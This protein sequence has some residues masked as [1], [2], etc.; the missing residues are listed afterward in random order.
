MNSGMRIAVLSTLALRGILEQFKPRLEQALGARLEFRFGA[1]QAILK[2]LEAADE[3]AWPDLL[4]LTGE[5]M[6]QLEAGGKVTHVRVL[7]SSGV[8]VAVRA[9]A[10]KPDIGTLEAFKRAI[11]DANSVAHSKVGASGLYFSG[12]IE[13]IPLKI[14]KRVVVESG[15][16]GHAVAAGEAEIGIQQL[17]ELA[18]VAGIDI[19]GGLPE[20]IQRMTEFAAGVPGNAKNPQGG[21]DLLKQ[22]CSE[23]V[24][25]AMPAAGINPA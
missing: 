21:A 7:G 24:R 14:K 9:G 25:A 5:A 3:Q 8:G 2:E 1:T 12:L 18:P 11:A 15:P 10:P 22:L 20:P 16:V 23:S 19:V 13:S 17:C 4:V 6:K